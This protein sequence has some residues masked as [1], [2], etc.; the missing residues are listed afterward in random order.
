MGWD[1]GRGS[2][3]PVIPPQ[4]LSMGHFQ[5]IRKGCNSVHGSRHLRPSWGD[6]TQSFRASR[7]CWWCI[8]QGRRQVPNPP[9]SDQLNRCG[10]RRT[11]PNPV[12]GAS[13]LRNLAARSILE[14]A[15]RGAVP[16]S[17][18]HTAVW[19]TGPGDCPRGTTHRFAATSQ[20]RARSCYCVKRL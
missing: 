20:R 14:T 3:R 1:V 5:A 6:F 15:P 19:T 9:A 13:P 2:A 11:L 12:V 17:A 18:P 16:D 4:P 10:S 7:L 8:T